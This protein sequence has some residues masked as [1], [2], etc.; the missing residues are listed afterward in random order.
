MNNY[1]VIWEGEVEAES[2]EEAAAEAIKYLR[3]HSVDE[4][5]FTV[6]DDE[7]NEVEVVV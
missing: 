5:Y 6:D 7:G 3:D 2:P 4:V 1:T